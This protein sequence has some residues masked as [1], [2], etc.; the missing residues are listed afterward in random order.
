MHAVLVI[1]LE[2]AHRG[3]DARNN[4]EPCPPVLY[5][6][7]IPRRDDHAPA[8]LLVKFG[9]SYIPW[10]TRGD[11]GRDGTSGGSEVAGG[12]HSIIA[13]HTGRPTL[14]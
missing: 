1:Q 13:V 11:G 5:T 8:T 3:T 6:T 10:I 2:L 12:R 4:P 7:E 14:F 9:E